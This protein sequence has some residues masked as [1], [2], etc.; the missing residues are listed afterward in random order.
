MGVCFARLDCG[1]ATGSNNTPMKCVGE[2]DWEATKK[3]LPLRVEN[4]NDLDAVVA[5]WHKSVGEYACAHAFLFDPL[6]SLMATARPFS[7]EAPAVM[8]FYTSLSYLHP[9]L[10]TQTASTVQLPLVQA[11]T[12]PHDGMRSN[13][14]ALVTSLRAVFEGQ[15]VA[16]GSTVTGCNLQHCLLV[17]VTRMARQNICH[18]GLVGTILGEKIRKFFGHLHTRFLLKH[19][20]WRVPMEYFAS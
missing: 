3:Q 7:L 17:T 9:D 11:P 12:V 6:N 19:W 1:L 14:L 4:I 13:I 18:S 5:L 8:S 20:C 15:H 2:G 10:A 16:K